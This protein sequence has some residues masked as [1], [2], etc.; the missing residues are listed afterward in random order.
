MPSTRW[1]EVFLPDESTQHEEQAHVFTELQRKRMK[2][3]GHGRALHRNQ[4]AALRAAFVVEEDLP[5]Y[6]RQG[7]FATPTAL[8]AHVR[9]SNGNFSADR[10]PDIRGFAIKVFGASTPSSADVEQNFTLVSQETLNVRGSADVVGI[11]DLS[12][13][14]PGAA[15]RKAAMKPQLT[16]SAVANFRDM[17][18]PFSGF[19]THDFFSVMPITFGGYAARL[20]LCAASSEISK[21]AR[22][23]LAADICARL[24]DGDLE[25]LFQAQFFEDESRTPIEDSSVSWDAPWLTVARLRLPRQAP[26]EALAETV[27]KSSF[28]AWIAATEHR[29]L[30]ELMRARQ[31]AYS[32]S[33]RNRS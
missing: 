29:P 11:V 2:K 31:A 13:S 21:E 20:K 12:T 10:T 28:N 30:G 25:F 19:A 8:E 15:L 6:A 23:D 27:E 22:K 5:D 1:R 14:A 24:A 17:V 26:D 3:Q 7:I 4:V 32:L 9:L 16:R 18:K 33:W